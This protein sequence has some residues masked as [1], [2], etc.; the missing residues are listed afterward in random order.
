MN[1]LYQLSIQ[2]YTLIIRIAAIFNPKA[3][4]WIS[5][6]KDIFEKLE[7]K[8][9]GN[10]HPLIWLHC[11][12]LGEFEQG[13]PIIE[14]LKEQLPETRILLTFFSP[15]GYEVR[16]NYAEADYIFYLPADTIGNAKRFIK[17][18]NPKAVIFVKYE[19][20]FNYIQQLSKRDIPIIIVSAIF[21]PTQHFFKSYGGWF[22]KGLAK[23][24]HFYVQTEESATLLQSIDINQV[25]ISGDTRFDRVAAIAAQ[26]KSFPLIEQFKGD[27]KIF[28]A[29]SS[30]PADEVLINTLYQEKLNLKYIIAP[31]E[32]HEEH[33]KAIEKQFSGATLRY[34]QA[35]TANI[36][37]A[38][39]LIID[40]IGILSHLYQYAYIAYIGGAFGKGLHNILEAATFGKPV[41]FGPNYEK[42][43]EAKDLIAN[44]GAFCI[45]NAEELIKQTSQLLSN[46]QVYHEASQQCLTYVNSMKGATQLI[47][48]AIKKLNLKK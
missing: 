20:W 25:T 26:C 43:K 38:E 31:H 13:R 33:I 47:V 10:T 6:R 22:R 1:I 17:I 46:E 4:L 21:R 40:S 23:I 36:S 44:G 28:L 24:N 18:V 35:N 29:G 3:K 27:H 9:A 14:S 11:A 15:S 32:V 42:F 2:I 41:I 37:Q 12:S 7:Q 48:A 45:H 16:K 30:W 34:S 19:F 8:L 39:V 5:G